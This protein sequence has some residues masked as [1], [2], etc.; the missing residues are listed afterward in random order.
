MS[1]DN[2]MPPCSSWCITKD[3]EI[4][5]AIFKELMSA[6]YGDAAEYISSEYVSGVIAKA[7]PLPDDV[8]ALASFL[9]EKGICHSKGEV[10]RVL[11]GG[12][13]SLKIGSRNEVVLDRAVLQALVAQNQVIDKPVCG[14][15]GLLQ[16]ART[17]LWIAYVWNDHNFEHCYKYAR[18]AAEELGINNLDEVNEF[19]SQALTPQ[20]TCK[21]NPT[22]GGDVGEAISETDKY[23][24][25]LH[26]I[27]NDVVEIPLEYLDKLRKAAKYTGGGE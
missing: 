9:M 27:E 24:D 25:G 10:K 20:E 23:F 22:Q 7:Q 19:I 16:L 3:N 15:G 5:N 12:G 14:E 17:T 13:M 2:E 8:Q 26:D 4:Q 18:E 11:D 6:G 21:E 1:E